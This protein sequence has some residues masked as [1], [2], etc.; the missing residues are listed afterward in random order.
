KDF[1]TLVMVAVLIAFPVAWWV[2]NKWLQAFAYRINISWQVFAL[3]ALMAISIALFTI[4]FK[5]IRA[6]LANPVKSLRT[7]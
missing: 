5:A 4:S 2:M 7:E 3:A 6:A 1:L